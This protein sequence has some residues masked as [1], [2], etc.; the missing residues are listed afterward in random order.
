MELLALASDARFLNV[1][2]NYFERQNVRFVTYTGKG[3]LEEFPGLMIFI[4]IECQ[5]QLVSPVDIWRQF[6][7]REHPEKRLAIAGVEAI[8]HHNYLDLL[9]LPRNFFDFFDNLKAVDAEDW[10]KL[11]TEALDMEEKMRRFYEGHGKESVTYTLSKISL[12]IEILSTRLKETGYQQAWEELFEPLEGETVAY[13]EEK[14]KELHRR[15]GHY[16]SFFQYLPFR[17]EMLEVGRL[18]AYVSPFFEH[19]CRE[20]V[21]FTQLESRKNIDRIFEILDTIKQEYA[22]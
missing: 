22:P 11:D 4:P 12:K 20:E 17:E 10:I 1:H 5:G 19:N 21:L 15:W 9:A 6:L 2:R 13:T 16:V 7:A 18:I 8:E 3:Q 14:W